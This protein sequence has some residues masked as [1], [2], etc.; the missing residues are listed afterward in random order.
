MKLSFRGSAEPAMRAS[1]AALSSALRSR[2]SFSPGIDLT[3]GWFYCP[4]GE[5]CA[6]LEEADF[7]IL[8]GQIQE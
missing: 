6:G 5:E 2:I 8:G 4:S 1:R 3:L 7:K